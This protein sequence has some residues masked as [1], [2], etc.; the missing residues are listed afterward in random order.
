MKKLIIIAGL[1]SLENNNIPMQTAKFLKE[2]TSKYPEIDFIF[3]ASY[4]KANRTSIDSYR[5]VGIEKGINI[6]L[7]IKNKLNVKLLT[8]AHNTMQARLLGHFSKI[9]CIQIPAFLCR[10]TDIVKTIAETGSIV[11][12]K[13]GQFLSPDD[14]KH[15]I[16]KIEAVGNK[17]IMVTERGA[18]FGYHNL[19]VD[20]RSFM[21]MKKFGYPVIFDVTHSQQK[22]S[23]GKETGGS[24]EFV[25]PMATGAIAT[26]NVDGLFF[27][28]HPN[29]K[30]AKS[31]KNTSLNFSQVKDLLY[32]T[33]KIWNV[34]QTLTRT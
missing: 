2:E 13:K 34:T 11:N 20:Y 21:I 32:Q 19:I 17:Q 26:G 7:N 9:D 8:D 18:C 4:D 3:K 5:G 28:C 22:P 23:E 12:I 14:I 24:T 6:L 16:Q 29:P 33:V 1:C 31:D 30:E 10:Q 25:I 27:E 15:V